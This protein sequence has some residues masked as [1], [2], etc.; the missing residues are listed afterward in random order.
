M[1]WG[2]IPLELILHLGIVSLI[3]IFLC[4]VYVCSAILASACRMS[5]VAPCTAAC[6]LY[7]VVA[8]YG[9]LPPEPEIRYVDQKADDYQECLVA[10]LYTH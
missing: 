3:T 2:S 1:R 4:K 5:V 6:S 9:V 7:T 8:S 10:E